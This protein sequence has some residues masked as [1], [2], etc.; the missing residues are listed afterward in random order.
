MKKIQVFPE[1]GI[2]GSIATILGG[3]KT[4]KEGL[5]PDGPVPME[6]KFAIGSQGEQSAKLIA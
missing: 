2:E 5:I 4:L 3:K 1:S 6:N